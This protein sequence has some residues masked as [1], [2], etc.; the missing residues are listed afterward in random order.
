MTG[1]AIIAMDADGRLVRRAEREVVPFVFRRRRDPLAAAVQGCAGGPF[2]LTRLFARA[3]DEGRLHGLR[4]EGIW[5]HV[6]TPDAIGK[7]EAALLASAAIFIRA[8]S[9]TFS[10][11]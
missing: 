2:S 3:E 10:L 4:L 11:I 1:A 8:C 7:A 5:M 9:D 6:G